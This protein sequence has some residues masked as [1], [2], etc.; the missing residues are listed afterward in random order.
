MNSD[1][2]P[3]PF[4]PI[5]AN[6]SPGATV[7]L[8]CSNATTRPKRPGEV[9]DVDYHFVDDREFDAMIAAG[10]LGGAASAFQLSERKSLKPASIMVGTFGANILISRAFGASGPVA[11][12]IVTLITDHHLPGPELP[13]AACIVNPNQPGCTFASVASSMSSM[14]ARPSIVL[15]FQ[16]KARKS[17]Q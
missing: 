3:A 7:K 5:T 8:T 14:A 11:L 17:R 10:V 1:V 2:L 15:M 13:A 12:G 6:S 9:D 4:G 16:V